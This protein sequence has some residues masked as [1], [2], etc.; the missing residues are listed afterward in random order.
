LRVGRVLLLQV[1]PFGHQGDQNR[2]VSR[3]AVPGRAAAPRVV[4]RLL[5]RH[6][7]CHGRPACGQ[8]AQ[9]RLKIALPVVM[10]HAR[11][12]SPYH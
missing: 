7:F 12:G 11:K 8:V 10:G 3:Y 2:H 5:N 9:D 1:A 4:H 6:Q